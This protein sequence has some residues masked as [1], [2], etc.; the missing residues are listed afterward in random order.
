MLRVIITWAACVLVCG[1]NCWIMRR[2]NRKFYRAMCNSWRNADSS[3]RRFEW[4]T[5][6]RSDSSLLILSERA[7][8]SN[9][10]KPPSVNH[11]AKLACRGNPGGSAIRLDLSRWRSQQTA[12]VR[13]A[14]W[15]PDLHRGF[16]RCPSK[17]RKREKEGGTEGEKGPTALA[18]VRRPTIYFVAISN[19]ASTMIYII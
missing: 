18:F 16:R 15:C 14:S 13:P 11:L 17:G 7:R 10:I 8:K 9:A 19:W 6:D 1:D 4:K 3:S 5:F 12:R 2:D